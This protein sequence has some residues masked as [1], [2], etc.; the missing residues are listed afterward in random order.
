MTRTFRRTALLVTVLTILVGSWWLFV[1]RARVGAPGRIASTTPVRG[2]TLV[3]SMSQRTGH[4]QPPRPSDRRG[5]CALAAHAGEARPDQ[6]RDGSTRTVAGGEVDQLSRWPDVHVDPARRC[7]VL[8]RRAVHVCRRPVLV[9]SCSTIRRS[10]ACWRRPRWWTA[11]RWRSRLPTIEPS[12]S[13]CRRPSHPA[14]RCS[15]AF[16]CFPRHQLQAALA[17]HTFRD[18]WGLKTAPGTMAGLGPFVL[19]RARAGA[20]AHAHAQRALLAEGRGRAARCRISIA[21]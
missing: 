16:R 17:A 15:T 6:R 3:V 5:R 2:G 11:G 13:R 20:A 7:H 10:T 4:V 1:H 19:D 21:S 14:W 18:A 9:S 12:R 8:R